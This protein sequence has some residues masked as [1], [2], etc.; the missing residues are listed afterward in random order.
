MTGPELDPAAAAHRVAAE[1]RVTREGEVIALQTQL[2]ELQGVFEGI[3]H[4]GVDA[5]LVGEPGYE[6]I[7]TLAGAEGPFKLIVEN[8]SQG[9]LTVSPRQVILFANRRFGEMV[10]LPSSAIV[11]KP[12][13]IFLGASSRAA[14]TDLL[15]VPPGGTA[16]AAVHLVGPD[17]SRPVSLSASC[18][19]V[20]GLLVRCLIATDVTSAH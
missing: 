12:I 14:V 19:D 17:G 9:A 16:D 7:Y 18:L 6:A 2:E 3:R 1:P 13:S 10:G 11:G 15:A 20:D 4:G 8:M 5:V